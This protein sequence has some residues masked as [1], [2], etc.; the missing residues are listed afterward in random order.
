VKKKYKEDLDYLIELRRKL[1]REEFD[2]LYGIELGLRIQKME[3]VIKIL[4]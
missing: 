4:I 1:G 3:D 2:N